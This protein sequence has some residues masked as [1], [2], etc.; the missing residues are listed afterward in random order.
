MK[1]SSFGNLRVRLV[2]LVLLAVIPALG[3]IF[4]TARSQRFAA[5]TAAHENLSRVANLTAADTL[6]VLNGAQ[7][8]LR[9]LGQFHEIRDGDP[10]ACRAVM[11]KFLEAYPFYS[12]LGVAS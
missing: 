11:A 4:Y 7:Q 1:A 3:L 12:S 9:G 5:N 10:A 6:R 8:L 2:L